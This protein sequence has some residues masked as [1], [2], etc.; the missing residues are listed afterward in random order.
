EP[1]GPHRQNPR[2]QVG[3][4]KRPHE[5]SNPCDVPV[6]AAR[7]TDNPKPQQSGVSLVDVVVVNSLSR[8]GSDTVPHKAPCASYPTVVQGDLDQGLMLGWTVHLQSPATP[9]GRGTSVYGAFR[10]PTAGSP[11]PLTRPGTSRFILIAREQESPPAYRPAALN[12][13]STSGR[14]PRIAVS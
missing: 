10:G 14:P 1:Y 5:L 7:G 3:S 6:L 4:I 8:A 9:E 2:G 13:F 11:T 12:H